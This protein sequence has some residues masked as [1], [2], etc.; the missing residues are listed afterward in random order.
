[1]STVAEQSAAIETSMRSLRKPSLRFW[2]AI[3]VLSIIVIVGIAAWIIQLQKGMGVAGYTDRSFWAIYIANVVTFIGFSYGGAVVSA[4]LLLTG[5]TWRAP[6]SRMAEG[7]ALVT[8]LIGAAFIFPHLGRPDR[9][10]NM[11]T[12]ANTRSPVF[13]DMVAI[14]TYTFATLI[15]FLLPLV[16]DMAILRGAHPEELGRFRRWTYR[17]VSKGWIGSPRQR[18]TLRKASIIMSILIIPLAVSVHSVLSWAFSLVSRPGWHESI[19]APYFVIAA[20]YSGVALAILV[21]AGFRKGYHLEAHIDSHHF[22]RLGYIM[23]TL[24]AVYA[25]LTF[26]DLLP[27]AYVG[28]RGPVAIIYAMLTGKAAAWFWFFIIAGVAVPIILVALPWTRNTKGMV[29]ASVLVV[30]AM[31]IKRMLMIV[32]TSGYDRLSMSF[33]GF[34]HFTWVSIAVTLAGTAAIPLL[35]M[36]L[37]HMVPLLAVDEMEELSREMDSLEPEVQAPLRTPIGNKVGIVAGVLLMIGLSTVSIG[38]AQPAFATDVVPV[39]AN[40]VVTA[41]ASGPKVDVTAT[42]TSAG[43]PVANVPVSFYASTPMFA[44]GNN[45][46]TLGQVPTDATGVATLNYVSASNGPVTFSADYYFNVEEN[47]ATGS[48]QVH[49]AGAV[50]PYVPTEK[51]RPLDANG[52]AL[53]R[54]LFA[55]VIAV[56]IIVIVQALR[57]RRSLRHPL[58]E[59]QPAGAI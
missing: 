40:V 56:F 31:W 44:P 49:I 47:P 5:A 15:F 55:V 33:G 43:Q 8:V 18:E 1:M 13:W 3:A 25:Y 59:R 32:E 10:L 17:L 2:I 41:V 29:V 27:S 14:I 21:V 34:F 57:V 38:R 42:V 51:T 6:L 46:I 28:E 54:I 35:L 26:A 37:F 16:P 53:V 30:F 24:G 11:I 12:H 4:I 39:A 52:R 45:R 20:L 22:V 9:L 23:A 48:T 58:V 7:M 19:W 50:S 36:L